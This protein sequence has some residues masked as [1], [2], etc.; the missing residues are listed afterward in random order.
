MWSGM[1]PLYRLLDGCDLA[2]R[3]NLERKVLER[4]EDY[5][6]F[7]DANVEDEL[8]ALISDLGLREPGNAWAQVPFDRGRAAR[9]R[10][11]NLCAGLIG[12]F[13]ESVVTAGDEFVEMPHVPRRRLDLLMAMAWVWMIDDPG[14]ETF[15]FGQR[16]LVRDLFQAYRENPAMLPQ[17]EPWRLVQEAG[18]TNEDY[19]NAG[20][21]REDTR[22]EQLE[23]WAAKARLICD[24]VAGMTDL[25]ALHVHG[26]MFTGGGSSGLRDL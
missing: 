7:A 6:R 22:P 8:E 21:T 26:E 4:D 23:V 2:A 25:Y 15:R 10:L 19:K 20:K 24:Q 3:E 11:K 9:A 13:I 14:Q 1:V 16:R 12:D 18:P 17:R 5:G